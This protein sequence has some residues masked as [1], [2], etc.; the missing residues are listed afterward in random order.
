MFYTV[1]NVNNNNL[2]LEMS[3][4]YYWNNLEEI[5][6]RLFKLLKIVVW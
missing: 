6:L 5:G 4:L 1:F 3:T 2:Q